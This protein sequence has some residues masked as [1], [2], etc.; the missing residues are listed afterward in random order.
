[1]TDPRN[2]V[3]TGANS[4][5]GLET[6]VALATIGDRVVMCCRNP[7]KAEAAARQVRERSGSD[8]VEVV[9]LDL[10]SFAS[11]R[12]AAETLADLTPT[13]DVLINNA[14]LIL[15]TRT[16]TA[17]GFETTFG[18]NHLGPFLLTSLLE[19]PLR[20]ARA[21]RIVNLS[22]M[23]HFMAVGGLHFDDLQTTR[24]YNGWVAYSRSKLANIH[25]TQELARRWPDVAVN[26]VHPGSVAT[27]FGR[28]GDT[29]GVS[30]VAM[31]LAPLV[32]LTPA[33]GATTSIYVATSDEGR[34]ITGRYWAKS[35]TARTAP[36]AR[37]RDADARLW[38]M[39]EQYVAAG[40]P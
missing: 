18:V 2:V 6:A 36:W 19:G 11:I 30:S 40:H 1:M 12:N 38:S 14:G 22:S 7:A 33:Q 23:A 17:E 21:P 39:S 24:H 32:S 20:S 29:R 34:N 28:D 4:G 5:V 15:S 27:G 37:D 25:F 8:A 16:T 3:I 35:H 10:A 31:K 26:A 13:I 9:A